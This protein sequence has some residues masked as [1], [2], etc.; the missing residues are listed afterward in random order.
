[1][2]PGTLAMIFGIGFLVT[3]NRD[4]INLSGTVTLL[5]IAYLV[6]YLPQAMRSVGGL[7]FNSRIPPRVHVNDIIRG[8]QVQSNA[9]GSKANQEYIAFAGLKSGDALVARTCRGAAIE[10]LVRD[11]LAV[12]FTP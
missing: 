1:M 8:C 6:L 10:V 9:S 3:F 2:A 5:F 12:Q 11:A 7:I 4:P